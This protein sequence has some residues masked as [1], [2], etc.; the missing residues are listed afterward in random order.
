[1]AVHEPCT[2]RNLLRDPSAASDLLRRIPGI[3]LVALP[4]N[5]ICCGAAGTYLLQRPRLSLS[6]LQPKLTA[7]AR[8]KAPIL[9]TTNTGCALHLQAGAR[10]ADLDVEVMH[11]VELVARQLGFDG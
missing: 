4:G 1:V 3:E 7:L 2:Q 6:L 11:P 8:L 10:E 9:V 5:A